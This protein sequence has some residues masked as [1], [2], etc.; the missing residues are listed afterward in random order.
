MFHI[1]ARSV[2]I[3]DQVPPVARVLRRTICGKGQLTLE[4]RHGL[5]PVNDPHTSRQ[6]HGTTTQRRLRIGTAGNSFV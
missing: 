6:T 2:G 3:E 5:P 4:D 1:E